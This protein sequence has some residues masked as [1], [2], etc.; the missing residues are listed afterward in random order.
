VF[1]G[2]NRPFL[3]I[4]QD[5]LIEIRGNKHP[6]GG[7]QIHDRQIYASHRF[8]YTKG[9]KVYLFTD[10]FADQ[11]GGGGSR[12][13]MTKGLRELI[14][15]FKSY[16]ILEQEALLLAAFNDWKGNRKQLDDVLIIG[17]EL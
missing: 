11:F 12:K 15:T 8:K 9:D 1:C 2:A 5:N 7:R 6:I 4:Q 16:P 10:G 17:F 3:F 13:L 14:R